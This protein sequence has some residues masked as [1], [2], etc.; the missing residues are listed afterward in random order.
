M[1]NIKK[2]KHIID[3]EVK[4]T[5]IAS[6][7]FVFAGVLTLIIGIAFYI[8]LIFLAILFF[9]A[10][11]SLGENRNYVKSLLKVRKFL[12]TDIGK[13]Y[14]LINSDIEDIDCIIKPANEV[15][16]YGIFRSHNQMRKSNLQNRRSRI[17]LEKRLKKLVILRNL[18]SEDLNEK[19]RNG[20]YFG[21]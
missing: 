16:Q 1:E 9:L 10:Y 20:T 17:I 8:P 2:I 5:K 14:D 19:K 15:I 4:K 7:A 11:V 12:I 21:Y 18:V 13:A 6:Y 3:L